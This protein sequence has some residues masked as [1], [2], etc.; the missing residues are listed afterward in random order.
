MKK[1][2][3]REQEL[4]WKISCISINQKMRAPTTHSHSMTFY[5]EHPQ[6]V[7]ARPM[8]NFSLSFEND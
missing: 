3:G 4:G 8:E 7:I 1:V 6:R 5:K 2:V